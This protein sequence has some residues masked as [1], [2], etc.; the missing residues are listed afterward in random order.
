MLL[1]I[2]MHEK[3][4]RSFLINKEHSAISFTFFEIALQVKR[5]F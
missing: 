2:L 4:L 5:K 3:S 1:Q